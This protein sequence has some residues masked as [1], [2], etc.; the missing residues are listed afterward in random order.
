MHMMK[1]IISLG[2]MYIIIILMVLCIYIFLSED[3]DAP[4]IVYP[5]ENITYVEGEN[6]K[7]L[8]KG[9]KAIDEK[10]GD[11]TDTLTIESIRVLPNENK[12]NITYAAKDSK[13]NIAKV[14]RIVNYKVKEKKAETQ[15]NTD[16]DKGN[17]V[18][19]DN[20]KDTA[21]NNTKASDTTETNQSNKATDNQST[22]GSPLPNNN[23]NISDTNTNQAD[24][25]DEPLKS[26]G[27]PII[28]LKTNSVTINAGSNFNP[29]NYIKEAVDDK[30][31]AWRRIVVSGNYNTKIHGKYILKFSVT[32][33]DGNRSNVEKMTL[34]V[35]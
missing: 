4:K 7:D 14:G 32:D 6:A 34:I 1:K 24:T 23:G 28:K 2:A 3:K 19:K 26:T 35:Q 9:V 11:V 22:V 12:V 5:N 21:M 31:D 27:A 18:T 10:D 16:V 8:L 33:S 13:N 17:N 15:T 25:T 29:I 30:D 20:T